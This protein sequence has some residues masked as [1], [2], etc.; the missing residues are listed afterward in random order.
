MWRVLAAVFT[1]AI[2]ACVQ[3]SPSPRQIEEQKM[4]AVPGKSV[5]YIVQDS[6]RDYNAGLALDDGKQ[7]RMWPGTF[8]RWVTSPGNHSI[9]SS[10][11][12]LNA[13]IN[14]QLDAGKVYFVQHSVS[15]IRGSPTDAR[16]RKLDERSGSQLV[17]SG[18]LCCPDD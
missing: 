14:L 7:I 3:I 8:Y 18:T 12:N 13:S 16:L 4:Q 15:G 1:M 17:T 2:A 6:F 10:D 5:V 9:K 11:G